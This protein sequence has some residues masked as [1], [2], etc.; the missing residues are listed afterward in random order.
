MINSTFTEQRQRRH[1]VSNRL[2]VDEIKVHYDVYSTILDFINQISTCSS[3]RDVIE[4]VREIF[5]IVFGVHTFKYWDSK[6]DNDRLPKDIN[7]LV[8]NTE[9]AFFLSKEDNKFCIRVN[10]HDNHFGAIEVSDFKFPENIEDYLSLAL[11]IAAIGSEVYLNNEQYKEA[12][13]SEQTMRYASTHD[14]LTDLYNRTYI[15]ELLL[16]HQILDTPFAVFMFDIDGLK[17]VNDIYG[18]AVGDKLIKNVGLILKKSFR[19]TDVVARIGGDEFV[20]ILQDMDEEGA[21]IF[22]NR[23]K[24]QI[25]SHN[26]SR[27]DEQLRISF[28]IGYAIGDKPEDTIETVMKIADEQMYNDKMN[29]RSVEDLNIIIRN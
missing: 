22:K 14:A 6:Y 16:D 12:I 27:Q 7:G 24:L 3:R 10:W 20:A 5:E 28:S 4:K 8:L 19:E 9:Q 2:V 13:K 25:E 11:E 17:F 23:I 29:K 1:R 15:N 26:S 18:H 21:E